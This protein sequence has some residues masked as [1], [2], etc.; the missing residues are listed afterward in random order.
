MCD[1]G[2]KMD[3]HIACKRLRI[4]L[5]TPIQLIQQRPT[6]IALIYQH[7]G[8]HPI[9]SISEFYTELGTEV[10]PKTLALKSPPLHGAPQVFVNGP[11]GRPASYPEAE[12]ISSTSQFILRYIARIG[13]RF[14]YVDLAYV[15]RSRLD[16]TMRQEQAGGPSE[17][18][19]S[20]N[21]ET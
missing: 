6:K 17:M 14:V 10:Q 21:H 12:G 13:S 1:I 5:R 19:I 2:A 18:F 9:H 16:Q 20:L 11:Y 7:A 8:L 4:C 3:I 15:R